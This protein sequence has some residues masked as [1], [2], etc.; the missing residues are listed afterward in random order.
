MYRVLC[1]EDD[2][3]V[4]EV[5]RQFIERVEGFEVIDFAKDGVEGLEKIASLQ[6]DLVFMDVFMPKLDGL[7]TLA[8]LREYNTTT[9]VI[10]VTAA[11]NVEAV[12]QALHLGVFDYIVKPF[13]L[14]RVEQAL[15]KYKPY[16]QLIQQR[17]DFTQQ[18]LDVLLHQTVLQPAAQ[19]I[20]MPIPTD[21][22]KGLNKATLEKIMR[23]L[24]QLNEAISAEN[25]ATQLGIAR[26]TARRYL[27]FLEKQQL[28]TV[29]IRYGNVGR[30]MNLYT[31]A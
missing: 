25:L 6:P 24:A 21:L 5:N 19:S 26:V 28:V 13:S 29:E 1:I 14:E 15:Q 22:P 27:D 12:E 7:Q 30:P 2:P 3:M 8:K 10:M 17:K 16:K 31:M 9:D 18:Q 11:T 4:R 20:D 23:H